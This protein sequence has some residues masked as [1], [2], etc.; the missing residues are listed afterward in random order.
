M[1]YIKK[2]L[3]IMY[4]N[5]L[6]ST[7]IRDFYTYNKLIKKKLGI[8]R[9][10]PI[11]INMNMILFPT[12]AYKAYDCIWVNYN[13]IKTYSSHGKMVVIIFNN[14]EIMEF[15]LSI[16]KMKIILKKVEIIRNYFKSLL[17]KRNTLLKRRI[18]NIE[19][20]YYKWYNFY[21]NNKTEV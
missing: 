11:F 12:K 20:K 10:I 6:L 13:E 16:N 2:D 21:G 17:W 18:F 4:I 19:I 14:G 9:N 15:D 5:K 3:G 8:C 1:N 7:Y